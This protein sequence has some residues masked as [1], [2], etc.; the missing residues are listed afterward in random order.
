MYL[1]L[2]PTV[3]KNSIVNYQSVGKEI[4]IVTTIKVLNLVKEG[5]TIVVFYDSSFKLQTFIDFKL[6]LNFNYIFIV[7][8]ETFI[9][10][11][12]YLGEVHYIKY[13][14]VDGRFIKSIIE[15]D[16]E[17]MESFNTN[18][19]KDMKKGLCSNKVKYVII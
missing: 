16:T 7:N 2:S 13:T 11:L 19:N 4:N 14:V 6:L 17:L 10:S 3:I 8:D 12:D 18:L 5:S 9:S 1:L 15:K